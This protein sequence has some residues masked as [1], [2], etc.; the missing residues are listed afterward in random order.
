[1]IDLKETFLVILLLKFQKKKYFSFTNWPVGSI[2]S[3]QAQY[4]K[5]GLL[6]VPNRPKL[7]KYN[8]QTKHCSRGFQI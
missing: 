7:M 5:S 8:F 2:Y 6:N 4:F 1:M 3:H